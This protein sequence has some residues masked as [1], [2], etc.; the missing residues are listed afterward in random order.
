MKQTERQA[1]KQQR[2]GGE[3]T[4]MRGRKQGRGQSAQSAGPE[5]VDR[6]VRETVTVRYPM[7]S[8]SPDPADLDVKYIS[9]FV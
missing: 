5:E 6:W 1:T 8:E 2:S 3:R 4:G 7:Q 9:A